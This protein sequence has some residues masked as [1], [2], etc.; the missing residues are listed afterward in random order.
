MRN[1]S[2]AS[3][4]GLSLLILTNLCAP[5][6]FLTIASILLRL[7]NSLSTITLP[8]EKPVDNKNQSGG[9]SSSSLGTE[10]E[11]MLKS[12]LNQ[13]QEANIDHQILPPAALAGCSAE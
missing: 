2:D 7:S 3:Y 13:Q 4:G 8:E 1:T 12:K 11:L 5:M 9:A 10:F 6:I